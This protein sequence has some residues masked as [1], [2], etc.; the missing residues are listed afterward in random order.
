MDDQND[1]KLKKGQ[2]I[3]SKFRYSIKFPTVEDKDRWHNVLVKLR[4]YYLR[5]GSETY[6]NANVLATDMLEKMLTEE[7]YGTDEHQATEVDYLLIEAGSKNLLYM[8][9][10]AFQNYA[11]GMTAMRKNNA[12]EVRELEKTIAELSN[13]MQTELNEKVERINKLETGNA[14][15]LAANQMLTK[16]NESLTSLKQANEKIVQALEKEVKLLNEKTC[17][18]H[19]DSDQNAELLKR[20]REYEEKTIVIGN[21][22][23]ELKHQ[24]QIKP[25]EAQIDSQNTLS[26]AI[27]DA[28]AISTQKVIQSLDSTIS[29]LQGQIV[30][31]NNLTSALSDLIKNERIEDREQMRAAKIE[32]GAK[33]EKDIV[34]F[35]ET[36]GETLKD[37]MAAG[38]EQDLASGTGTA[39]ETTAGNLSTRCF[40]KIPRWLPAEEK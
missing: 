17:E 6:G 7:G 8:I 34:R 9:R 37:H 39:A 12:K 20:K 29:D 31:L 33:A 15:L 28:S 38:I 25:K 11:S 10:A 35:S 24:H 32:E 40:A 26:K 2:K 23:S 14:D 4:K 27:E 13:D 19:H 1:P 36:L 22:L 21:E 5:D 3:Q 16:D 30:K 18:I